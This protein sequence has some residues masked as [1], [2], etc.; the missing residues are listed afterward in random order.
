MPPLLARQP[1]A[2]SEEIARLEIQNERF[3]AIAAELRSKLAQVEFVRA[4]R[5]SIDH[6]GPPGLQGLRGRDRRRA[7]AAR[8][9]PKA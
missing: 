5:L 8:R 1:P 6:K 4:E 9:A 2:E 3:K 7:R